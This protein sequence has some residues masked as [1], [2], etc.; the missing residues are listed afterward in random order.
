MKTPLRRLPLSRHGNV[1]QRRLLLPSH[2]RINMP[3]GFCRPAFLFQ[4]MLGHP[5]ASNCVFQSGE[6]IASKLYAFTFAQ[7]VTLRASSLFRLL[8][9]LSAL[10]IAAFAQWLPLGPDG[11]DARS[12]AYDPS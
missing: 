3:V 11:G 12:F 9:C 6:Q 2:C 1:R 5:E 10:S 8:I 7:G 4:V